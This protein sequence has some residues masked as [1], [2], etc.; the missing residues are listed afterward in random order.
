MPKRLDKTHFIQPLL[1][2][3]F[4]FFNSSHHFHISLLFILC[5]RSPLPFQKTHL[6]TLLLG[7][8]RPYSN[9]KKESEKKKLL[10]RHRLHRSSSPSTVFSPAH[11]ANTRIFTMASQV[12]LY[13]TALSIVSI[14]KA[15]YPA[16]FHGIVKLITHSW[17]DEYRKVLTHRGTDSTLSASA[18]KR[19]SLRLSSDDN[20][21]S[22]AADTFSEDDHIDDKITALQEFVNVSFTPVECSVIC[23]TE[24]VDL[25]FT[26]PL[27][28]VPSNV[29]H[30]KY[31]A[32]QV[33]GD[34]VDSGSRLL[35]ITAPLSSAGIPIFFIPTYFSDYVLVPSRVQS[36]VTRALESRGF[37][38]SNTA[39]SYVNMT[40]TPASPVTE[41][42]LFESDL[43][44]SADSSGPPPL[45][46]DLQSLGES[47][48]EQ[49][50]AKGVRPEINT[51]T[52]LLLTGARAQNK[53]THLHS[54][55]YLK[56]IEILITPPTYFSLTI[57]DGLEVS[58]IIN[59]DM[60]HA[61][62]TELLLGSV[63]DFLIPISFDLSALP[64]DS[65]GIVA[66]VASRLLKAPHDSLT[67]MQMSYLSTAK[68]GVVMISEEDL[69]LAISALQ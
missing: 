12:Q 38:F 33:D 27:G 49:F 42:P 26:T 47:T 41:K 10:K 15:S 24:L 37:V 60:V 28:L 22:P 6:L 31:L 40:D 51:S 34:G 7:Y 9:L 13:S 44:N 32:I 58:F 69:N 52:K 57:T 14:P 64:E 8:F 65:T 43:T 11:F 48:F 36:T 68:S 3:V 53:S 4:F 1:C 45:S 25:L 23:P 56:I 20:S 19:L 16:F 50:S 30:E 29:L 21:S 46:P 18:T 17:E 35:E 5:Y 66:G 62:P 63:T 59:Q 67:I 55:M 39:N 61:F 2:K 54:S